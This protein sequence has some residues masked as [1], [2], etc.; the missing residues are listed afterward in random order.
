[1]HLRAIGRQFTQMN[2]YFLV[3]SFEEMFCESCT[4]RG[5]SSVQQAGEDGY[6]SRKITYISGITWI[7]DAKPLLQ[8]PRS[9]HGG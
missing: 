2:A 7:D 6:G 5:N 3:M 8:P 1:M 4:E 9:P